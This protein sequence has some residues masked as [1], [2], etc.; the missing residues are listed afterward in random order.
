MI[1]DYLLQVLDGDQRVHHTQK[2]IQYSFNCPICQDHRS[3]FFVNLDRQ[4]VYCH[5]CQYGNSIITFLSDFN[6]IEWRDALSV[7]R[8]YQGE[9]YQLPESLED[10]V[11][12]RLFHNVQSREPNKVVHP[13]PDEFI[14][15]EEARGEAGRKA[16]KYLKSRGITLEMCER[17]YIGYCSEGHYADR[18]IMPD[19]ENNE[20]I[21]WQARTWT[22]TPTNPLIKKLFR[23]VLNPSLTEEQIQAGLKA[24]D[25]SEVISNIDFILDDGMAVL[26]EGKMDAYS[27]GDNGACMHGKHM[28]DTQFMKLVTNKDKID[29]IFVMLDGDALP[30]A[31]K[32][33]DRLYK[34]FDN[35]YVCKLPQDADPN[36]LGRR[37]CLEIIKDAMPYNSMFAIKARLKG[38]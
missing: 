26:C 11:F 37:K 5:N 8:E 21:Y 9:D 16:V 3:R 19:F 27:I 30:N 12:Q 6:H 4:V 34:H 17:Y 2:G 25:K 13:L 28:S 24:V 31:I 35:I 20:L 1:I 7:Y 29:V 18:I 38:W 36:S 32:T 33:A 10:E 14:P 23:K 15:V 22:P